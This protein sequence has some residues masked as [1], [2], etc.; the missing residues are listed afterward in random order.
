[1]EGVGN[2]IQIKV[3]DTMII[4]GLKKSIK[5]IFDKIFKKKKKWSFQEIWW[6][7]YS[8][9]WY[10]DGRRMWEREVRGEAE[11]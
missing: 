6:V 3:I 9:M 8:W 2:M 11:M 4:D 7:I 1:M 5:T 10:T